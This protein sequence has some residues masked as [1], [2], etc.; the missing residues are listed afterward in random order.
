LVA[1]GEYQRW[2]AEEL[3]RLK[4]GDYLWGWKGKV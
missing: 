1:G 3:P 4:G 2:Y